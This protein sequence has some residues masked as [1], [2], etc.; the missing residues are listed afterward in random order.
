VGLRSIFCFSDKTPYSP[1]KIVNI[2]ER[3]VAIVD[4]EDGGSRFLQTMIQLDV[5]KDNG[6]QGCSN[7]L[8]ILGATLQFKAPEG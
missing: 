5:P 6:Y 3:H 1:I 4:P 2:S 8:K 7:S